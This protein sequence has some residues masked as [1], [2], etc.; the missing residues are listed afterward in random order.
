[1]KYLAHISEDGARE[2]LLA[3]HLSGTAALASQFASPFGMAE[4]AFR[5]GLAHDI[6]K[7][8]DKFQR[9]IR[10]SG[11]KV[12]HATAGALEMVRLFRDFP[13]A[14]CISGHHA[15]LPDGGTRFDLPTDSS[16]S[17]KIKRKPGQDIE[18]YDAYRTEITLPAVAASCDGA[19]RSSLFFRI[20]MLYSCLV[21]ADFLDT[22]KFVLNAD[23]G[24]GGYASLKELDEKLTAH[25]RGFSDNNSDL[26]RKRAEIRQILLEQSALQKGLF[27]LTVPTGGGK[28]LA[29]MSFGLRHAIANR[30]S[31]IIYIIPYCSIIEQTQKTFS[32]IFGGENVVAHYANVEYGTAEDSSEKDKRYLA[33]E[34][35]DAP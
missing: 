10:G 16:F 32:A 22:E 21:D 30:L 7:Y 13:S 17:G 2:Q 5:C 15:G 31:R 33:A 26:N 4:I 9:R 23:A 18:E 3:D 14:F 34:N 8:S 28:T 20:R 35:W 24:R 6:G 27:S 11:E 29:S 19:D 1:M 25:M 12:D